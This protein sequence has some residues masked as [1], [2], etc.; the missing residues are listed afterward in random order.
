MPTAGFL[1]HKWPQRHTHVIEECTALTV[2]EG[3]LELPSGKPSSY[4]YWRPP[5]YPGLT[6]VVR[7]GGP[8]LRWWWQCPTCY[9][10]VENVY[11]P[12]KAPTNDWRCRKCHSLVYA[13][14]RYG[15]AHP[16][17][18]VLTHRKRR[19]AIKKAHRDHYRWERERKKRQFE[20]FGL[21]PDL[22]L[23]LDTN[24]QDD[25]T[26][27]VTFDRVQLKQED[28]DLAQKIYE[29]MLGKFD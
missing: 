10:R 2:A 8:C 3:L 5:S 1:R 25:Q 9:R 18:K 15:F 28:L 6:M 21:F 16:L 27:E 20:G 26:P 29:E 11:R 12:P 7:M 22:M 24:P 14:Q 13:S 19:T 23:P 4:P 17:R